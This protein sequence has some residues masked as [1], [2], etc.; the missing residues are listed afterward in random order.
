V[1]CLAQP[2]PFYAIG[3]YY[4]TFEQV[5]D[6]EVITLH[7]PQ[8]TGQP[9]ISRGEKKDADFPGMKAGEPNRR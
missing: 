8:A 7:S 4:H 3:P 2:E 1:V 9:T 5:E 6:S